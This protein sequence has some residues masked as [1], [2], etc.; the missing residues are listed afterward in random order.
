MRLC[1]LTACTLIFKEYNGICALEQVIYPQAYFPHL[2]MGS[3]EKV[4][5]YKCYDTVWEISLPL[6]V[7]K[8]LNMSPCQHK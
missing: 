5:W 3:L 7:W 1:A 6:R 8:S 2:E 4:L